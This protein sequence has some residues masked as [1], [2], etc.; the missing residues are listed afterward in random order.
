[1]GIR[2]SAR[3]CYFLI[4]DKDFSY[5]DVAAIWVFS[6]CEG[7]ENTEPGFEA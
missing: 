1:M 6:F 3:K 5:F 2:Y 4:V 7:Y